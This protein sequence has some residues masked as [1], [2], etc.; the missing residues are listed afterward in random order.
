MILDDGGIRIEKNNDNS[1][2]IKYNYDSD[3]TTITFNQDGS[4]RS[5][6]A[7]VVLE[8]KNQTFQ[9]F[10]DEYLL[11]DLLDGKKIKYE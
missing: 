11:D 4:C 9:K 5:V 10:A 1:I 8:E 2:T 6:D 7:D 3:N